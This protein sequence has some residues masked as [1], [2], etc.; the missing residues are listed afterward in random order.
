M[1]RVN[2]AIIQFSYGSPGQHIRIET[3]MLPLL[4]PRE[5]LI[6]MRFAPINPADLNMMEGRY[7]IQPSLP[8]VLGNEGVGVVEEKGEEVSSFKK[9]D[10]VIIPFTK[11]GNWHGTWCEALI[12]EEE[13]VYPVPRGISL[14]QAAM[15]TVNPA[16][17]WMLLKKFVPLKKGDWVIQNGANSGVGRFVMTFAKKSGYK[18]VNIVRRPELQE[19][20]K[21]I[22]A[23][24]VILMDT[25]AEHVKSL[26]ER[27]IKLALNCVGGESVN[28]MAKC[29]S[30]GAT[31]VTYGAMAKSPISVSNALLIYRDIRFVGGNRTRWIQEI[32]LEEGQKIFKKVLTLC[33]KTKLK[34]PIQS[35]FPLERYSEA[36][37]AASQSERQGKILLKL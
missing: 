7:Y 26:K 18:T 24:E 30:Q 3:R 2:K 19:E 36:I 23:D 9:G 5:L 1:K 6:R 16:T 4:K 33:Q 15:C 12:A 17:A 27:G 10:I 35:I 31:V 14:E 11:K 21:R 8:A 25:C 22:G 34:I 20:L 13:E 28:E 32:S 29:L 37:Q